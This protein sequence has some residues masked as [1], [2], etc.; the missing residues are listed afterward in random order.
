MLRRTSSRSALC[1]RRSWRPIAVLGESGNWEM[2]ATT[3]APGSVGPDAAAV[4]DRYCRS[5]PGIRDANCA[6]GCE[7]VFSAFPQCTLR[8]VH[9][10]EFTLNVTSLAASNVTSLG[11]E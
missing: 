11:R 1:P 7:A 3:L 8:S 4:L 2:Q 5:P 9:L 10:S 6:A